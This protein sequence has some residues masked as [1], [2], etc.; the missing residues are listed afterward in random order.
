MKQHLIRFLGLLLGLSILGAC[1]P[2]HSEVTPLAKK[3]QL[4]ATALTFDRAVGTQEVTITSKNAS[5]WIYTITPQVEWLTVAQMQNK[6]TIATTEN[7]SNTERKATI[8]II[9]GTEVA[10]LAITQKAA[11][12]VVDLTAELSS[13]KS[14]TL[15][16]CGGSTLIEVS[17]NVEEWSIDA[18][19]ESW[20][21]A[22]PLKVANAIKVEVER[23]PL[24]EAR[25]AELTLKFGDGVE[26][27]I[28][29]QQAGQLR[30][31]APYSENYWYLIFKDIVQYE[32]ARGFK[33]IQIQ[34][35]EE[36]MFQDTPNA[37]A[38]ETASDLLPE[39]A[40]YQDLGSTRSYDEAY[41]R[42]T[43]PDE[44]REGGGYYQYL[45]DLGYEERYNSKP[46]DPKLISPDG[47]LAA[48]LFFNS[49][50]A[51]Y[52][53]VFTAQYMPR[54]AY[55]TFDKLP[56][57][58]EE[59]QKMIE[60]RSVRFKDIDKWEKSIGSSSIF[61]LTAGQAGDKQHPDEMY[62]AIYNTNPKEED[63]EQK[64][65]HFY[66][67]YIS[68]LRPTPTP[69]QLQSIQLAWLCFNDYHKVL[70]MTS[71]DKFRTTPE[72]E[73]LAKKEGYIWHG[74]QQD[75]IHFVN[76]EK[77]IKMVVMLYI[78]PDL[79]GN[80][81][82]ATIRYEKLPPVTPPA[83]TTNAVGARQSHKMA[84]SAVQSITSLLKK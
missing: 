80:K 7:K 9:A 20:F 13:A 6:L 74:F 32:E 29:L 63:A 23:N 43:D 65:F 59:L 21:K 14:L 27:K 49:K 68:A 54:K 55:P 83:P 16:A 76:K 28:P 56:A 45:K 78:Q 2:K 3:L 73:A 26:K 42:I 62:I 4:S 75:G 30:Y 24:T 58:P 12:L 19:K 39:V 66:Q 77:G 69:E 10:H 79:F 64:Q 81:Y 37:L 46:D 17:A 22:T 36:G 52:Y 51:S 11:D 61:T 82:T 53:V 25:E 31:F 70:F 8:A 40:Y 47:F 35:G 72:F 84:C 38:F 15:P 18:P 71:K 44:M 57:Y 34:F 41:I 1:Q 67:F 5:E 50:A 48:R 60:D 33:V